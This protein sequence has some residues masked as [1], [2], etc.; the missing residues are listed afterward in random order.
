MILGTF[1]WR[2]M[3]VQADMIANEIV[4]ETIWLNRVDTGTATGLGIIRSG[5]LFPTRYTPT[6][7]LAIIQLRSAFDAFRT[8][9]SEPAA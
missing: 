3:Q 2:G 7:D 1:P 6:D 4:G 5:R 8:E 9:V